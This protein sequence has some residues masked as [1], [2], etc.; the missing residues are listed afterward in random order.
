MRCYKGSSV[1]LE[2]SLT[3]VKHTHA[4]TK[5]GQLLS[6]TQGGHINL[7]TSVHPL[8][9]AD[10]PVHKHLSIN[11]SSSGCLNHILKQSNVFSTY[12]CI[13]NP[14]CNTHIHTC[15]R[16]WWSLSWPSGLGW[17]VCEEQEMGCVKVNVL[18]FFGDGIFYAP[19]IL[20]LITSTF[21]SFYLPP[22]TFF[23]F[24]SILSP[25][26]TASPPSSFLP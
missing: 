1:L 16:W 20:S 4:N 6:V 26:L 9:E 5:W 23:F 21:L 24:T 3:S 8:E 12:I 14:L 11:L 22:L 18:G 10:W 19:L 2:R 7:D 25:P 15:W 13:T 17:C